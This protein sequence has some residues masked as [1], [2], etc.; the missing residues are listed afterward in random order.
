MDAAAMVIDPTRFARE[1]ARLTG[2]LTPAQLPRLADVLADEQGAVKYLVEGHMTAEAEPALRIELAVDVGVR[3]Q[4]CLERLPL[5]LEVR[6]DIVLAA[7]ASE[8]DAADDEDE[9]IDVIPAVARLD[10]LDLI[11]Q[12]VVLGLPMAP[13]HA[14]DACGPRPEGEANK[15]SS[16]FS[17]L[18]ELKRH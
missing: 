7:D 14:D 1:G 18:A 2:V 8:L 4:R 3:C 10:L 17:V 16:P 9:D 15:T 11:E 5:H 6:R 13:R 12:E